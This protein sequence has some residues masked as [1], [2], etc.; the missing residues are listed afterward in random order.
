MFGLSTRKLKP[1]FHARVNDTTRKEV[2]WANMRKPVRI[3]II[4][5]CI[6]LALG[7]LVGVGALGVMVSMRFKTYRLLFELGK[8]DAMVAAIRQVV[9]LQKN[10]AE[11]YQDLWVVL[12]AVAK[13]RD[14]YYVDA[15]LS[16]TI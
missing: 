10:H 7:A 13:K 12:S 4:S 16:K 14:G 15:L 11:K 2:T 3:S 6:V 1:Q 9:G 8:R 5:I